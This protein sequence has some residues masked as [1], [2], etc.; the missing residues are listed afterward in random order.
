MNNQTTSSAN[1]SKKAGLPPGSLIHVGRKKQEKVNLTVIDYDSDHFEEFV[2]EKPEDCKTYLKKDSVT[3]INV[4][5]LHDTT[6]I[7]SLG[8]IFN[9]HPLLLEDMLN[10]GHRPTIEEYDDC[11]FFTLRTLD[12]APV[13]NKLISDQ[14]SFVLG[15]NWVISFQEQNTKLYEGLQQRLKE[16]KGN[17]RNQ[18]VDYLFYR[19]VDT[20]VDN[21]FIVNEKLSIAAED[22]EEKV[23]REPDQENL[24]RIQFM[25]KQV[26]EF[27]KSVYPLREAVAALHREENELIKENTLR[28]IRDVYEHILHVIDTVDT[29]RDTLANIMDLYLSGVSNR[30]NE[31]MKVL[32]IIATIFIPLTFIAGVYGMNFD[33]MPELHWKYSY[34]VIWGIMATLFILMIFYF[35]RKKW[36]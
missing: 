5:G 21:Y 4:S 16:S 9:L 33:N 36:L 24:S 35:K 19:L 28:Y 29:F 17:I 13:K 30:M 31:V 34:F 2:C 26:I 32:T 12:L 23:L 11:I 8:R 1:I 15:K 20:I 10:T 3:W 14:V 7:E 6:V 18:G 27:R 22:L 25:K